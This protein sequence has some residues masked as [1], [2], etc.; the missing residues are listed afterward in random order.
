[1]STPDNEKYLKDERDRY[2]ADNGR[3]FVV[4][5]NAAKNARRAKARI[6]K[7]EKKRGKK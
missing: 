5:A 3:W 1:M 6:R 4:S 7:A 2:A